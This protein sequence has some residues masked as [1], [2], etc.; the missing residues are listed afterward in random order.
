MQ[1]TVL[2]HNDTITQQH[3][4][5][6]THH[7]TMEFIHNNKSLLKSMKNEL[8]IQNFNVLSLDDL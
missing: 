7:Q 3:A 1:P 2:P 5:D 4:I 6:N 8:G